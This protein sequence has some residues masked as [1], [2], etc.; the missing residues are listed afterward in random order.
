MNTADKPKPRGGVEHLGDKLGYRRQF[1]T[2]KKLPWHVP[3][4]RPG[5]GPFWCGGR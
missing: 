4:D 2:R 3:Q 1:L 5:V